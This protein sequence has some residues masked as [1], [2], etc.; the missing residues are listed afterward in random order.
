M[1]N[2]EENF[3]SLPISNQY[4]DIA[5]SIASQQLFPEVAERLKCNTLAVLVMRD[6]LEMMGISTS[7]QTSD[8]WHPVVRLCADVAD[9]EIEGIGK[10]EC[11]SLQLRESTCYVPPEVWEDRIGYVVVQFEEN[12][13]SA[14]LLGFVKRVSTEF[15]ALNRLEPI[16]NL[17]VAIAAL[18]ES[19]Q[20]NLR[21]NEVIASL[22]NWL[23]N[24]FESG[25]EEIENL[26]DSRQ[27]QYAY[28]TREISRSLHNDLD[29][30]TEVRRG[31]LI[32]FVFQM[33]GCLVALIITISQSNQNEISIRIALYPISETFLPEFLK[34][35]V[36]NDEGKV[37][38]QAQSR[39]I[40]NYIQIQLSGNTGEHFSIRVSLAES[41][42]IEN[43]II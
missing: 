33:T 5:R 6:Y 21:S 17:C 35:A 3:L 23:Q 13:R 42:L 20:Q 27:S 10:L 22:S 7:L 43:F 28:R 12:C 29:N 40:D 9:L 34:L 4:R 14:R 37:F 31:K 30:L 24:L 36:L 16:E 15:I 41:Y 39:S 26:L 11:R 32:D 1:D 18:Q 19:S 8:S 2:L 25:W 38:L